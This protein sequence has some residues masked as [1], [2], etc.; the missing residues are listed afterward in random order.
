MTWALPSYP[1]EP[2]AGVSIQRVPDAILTGIGRGHLQVLEAPKRW[3][4]GAVHDLDGQLVASSQRI[5]GLSGDHYAASDQLQVSPEARGPLLAGTWLYG[6]HWMNPFGHFVTETLTTLWPPTDGLDGVVFHSWLAPVERA[7]DWQR[8]LVELAGYGS[9]PLR[10]VGRQRLRVE[11]LLVPTRSY[12]PNGWAS[13]GRP[14][15]AADLGSAAQGRRAAQGAP[16][17]DPVQRRAGSPGL[18]HEIHLGT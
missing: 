5:G 3:V 10:F 6:G 11:E 8:E 1:L 9:L 16:V 13:G 17:A 7:A 14:G 18:A 15:L 2:R 4:R 12:V